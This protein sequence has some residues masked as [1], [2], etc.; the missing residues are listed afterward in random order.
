MAAFWLRVQ[1]W[2]TL[3][4]LQCTV[5]HLCSTE[6]LTVCLARSRALSHSQWYEKA[7]SK[8]GD[9]MSEFRE[10]DDF[11][12]WP[13][14]FFVGGC[15]GLLKM[16]YQSNLGRTGV[17]VSKTFMQCFYN[18]RPYIQIC[19]IPHFVNHQHLSQDFISLCSPEDS[20]V[21]NPL[22]PA[23]VQT[24]HYITVSQGNCL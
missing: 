23:Q 22:A 2:V 5:S 13:V 6:K 14:H 7:K 16:I 24:K 11:I 19:Y 20:D 17:K 21:D 1:Q 12:S 3:P 4:V 9:E 10:A 8:T 15:S 18:T